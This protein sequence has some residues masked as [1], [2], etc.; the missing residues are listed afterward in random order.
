LKKNNSYALSGHNLPAGHEKP[1]HTPQGNFDSLLKNAGNESM[2]AFGGDSPS[3]DFKKTSKDLPDTLELSAQDKPRLSLTFNYNKDSLHTNLVVDHGNSTRKEGLRSELQKDPLV[4]YTIDYLYKSGSHIS[5]NFAINNSNFR[6]LIFFEPNDSIGVYLLKEDTGLLTPFLTYD[7]LNVFIS[8]QT[9]DQKYTEEVQ[10]KFCFTSKMNYC[11]GRDN[12]ISFKTRPKQNLLI[13]LWAQ[14]YLL[15]AAALQHISQNFDDY[16]HS[17]LQPTRSIKK[18]VATKN[19]T[20]YHQSTN[21]FN[22]DMSDIQDSSTGQNPAIAG[23]NPKNLTLKNIAVPNL[24]FML[25][26][27][28]L[29]VGSED[30]VWRF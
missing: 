30:S 12:V 4:S 3:K 2:I 17:S 8:I 5:R 19:S 9:I 13:R 23:K 25:L 6:I 7:S 27:D 16:I 28:G 11:V 22:L 26:D 10:F 15:H 20:Q 29:N 24:V 21:L 1:K 14:Q 18:P